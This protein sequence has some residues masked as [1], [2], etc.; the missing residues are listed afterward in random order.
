M[1]QMLDNERVITSYLPTTLLVTTLF[2][3]EEREFW[4]LTY[5]IFFSKPKSNS[6]ILVFFHQLRAPEVILKLQKLANK[7]LKNMEFPK[8][9]ICSRRSSCQCFIKFRTGRIRVSFSFKRCCDYQ[10][11]YLNIILFVFSA[12]LNLKSEQIDLLIFEYLDPS[13]SFTRKVSKVSDNFENKPDGSCNF[14]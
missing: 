7:S 5:Y 3:R 14:D 13:L 6:R 10:L 8:S 2:Q 9:F 12:L 11:L 1:K 4:W